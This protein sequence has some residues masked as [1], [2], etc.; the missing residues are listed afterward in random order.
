MEHPLVN[1]EARVQTPECHQLYSGLA[2]PPSR[3][4]YELQNRVYPAALVH[5]P[6]STFEWIGLST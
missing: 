3:T 5:S 2:L 6:D 4:V 1:A